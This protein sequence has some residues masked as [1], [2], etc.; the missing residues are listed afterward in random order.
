ML[1]D[2]TAI[3]AELDKRYEALDEDSA[4]R[5]T[6]ITTGPRWELSSQAGL[7]SKPKTTSLHKKE[8]AD[9]KAEAFDLLDALSRSGELEIEHASLHVVIAATHCFDQSL[10]DTVVQGNVNPIEKVE[11]STLIVA[12]VVHRAETAAMLQPAEVDR[13]RQFAPKLLEV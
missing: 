10:V 9:S 4:L 11:R 5:P 2:Y 8:Q 1:I 6:T 13:I 7:L 3:P 12:G